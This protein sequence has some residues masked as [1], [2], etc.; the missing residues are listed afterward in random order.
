[1][2]KAAGTGDGQRRRSFDRIWCALE[3]RALWKLDPPILC[4]ASSVKGMGSI[5]KGSG[6]PPSLNSLFSSCTGL[7]ICSPEESNLGTPARVALGYLVGINGVRDTHTFAEAR[8]GHSTLLTFRP[9]KSS[10]S[11]KPNRVS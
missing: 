11:P 5:D 3:L 8:R 2:S 10:G 4:P 7:P 6:K 9:E 1:M